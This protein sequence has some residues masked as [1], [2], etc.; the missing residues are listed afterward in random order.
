[1]LDLGKHT[2][3][4]CEAAWVHALPCTMHHAQPAGCG[5]PAVCQA[6]RSQHSQV[7]PNE[8]TILKDADGRDKMLGQGGFGTVYAGRMNG[9]LDVAVKVPPDVPPV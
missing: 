2:V 7:R 9:I 3:L 6:R 5:A 8:I 1:M 4:L